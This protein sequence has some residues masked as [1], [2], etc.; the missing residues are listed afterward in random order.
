M[1]AVLDILC[2]GFPRTVAAAENGELTQ[3]YVHS[4]SELELFIEHNKQDKN[5]YFNIARMREDKR[6][7]IASVPFDFDSPMKEAAFEEGT[8]DTEKIRRMREDD[9]LAYKILGDVW[10][11]VQSLV[12]ECWNQNIPVITVFSG[13]GVHAHILYQER[14]DPVEA[15]VTT[16]EH[17][18]QECNLDT[19]DRQIVSD[20]KRILRIPNSQR[21]DRDGSSNAFCIP[22]TELEVLNNSLIDML[23]RC[24]S[25]KS[26]P[27]HSRYE[28]QNRPRMQVYEDIDYDESSVGSVELDDSS[29]EMSDDVE[30]IVRNCIPVPCIRERFLSRN[31]KHMVRFSGVVHLYQAGFSPIEVQNIIAEIGWIDYDRGITEKMTENIWKNNYSELPCSKLQSLG[32]CVMGSEFEKFGDEVEDCETYRYTSGE[33]LYP[34]KQ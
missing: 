14:V 4:E 25:P 27:H 12:Q 29:E 17:F 11:D 33:A 2:N 24:S 18:I 32:L 30:Y 8:S 7:V 34:Y 5:L 9:D 1:Q 21:V 6:P 20:T 13:L 19:Y 10:D 31:P 22:M 28:M 26:I 3:T 16:S 15:K 23:E